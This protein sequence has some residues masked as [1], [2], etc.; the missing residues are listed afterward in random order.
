CW[1]CHHLSVVRLTV[2][3]RW[4]RP[5]QRCYCRCLLALSGATTPGWAVPPPGARLVG[6]STAWHKRFHRLVHSVKLNGPCF[7]PKLTQ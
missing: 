2:H 3:R 4:N 5:R 1:W 7:R 6:G